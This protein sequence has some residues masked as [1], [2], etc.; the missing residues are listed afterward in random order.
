VLLDAWYNLQPSVIVGYD[1]LAFVAKNDPELR[2]TIDSHLRGV[3]WPTSLSAPHRFRRCGFHPVLPRLMSYGAHQARGP[4]TL[5]AMDYV[6]VELK[7]AHGIPRWLH[8][9]IITE[10]LARSAYSKYAY[11]AR[12]LRPNLFEAFEGD[13]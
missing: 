2:I 12:D 4:S 5:S 9:I 13:E 6:V 11:V 10:N 1:R 7:F 8:D 3:W